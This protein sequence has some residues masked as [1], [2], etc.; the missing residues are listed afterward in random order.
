M[1][2]PRQMVAPA[3]GVIASCLLLVASG[4]LDQGVP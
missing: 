4:E 1:T 3:L 2:V